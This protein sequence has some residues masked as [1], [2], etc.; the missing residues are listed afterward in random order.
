M[1]LKLVQ[2]F[3]VFIIYSFFGYVMEVIDC[4]LESKKFVNRGFLL[5]PVCPIYG[6]GGLL[7]WF[8]L[9][10]YADDPIVVFV[11]GMLL[12]SIVEYVTGWALEKIFH[13]KWWDYSNRWDSINGHVCLGNSI[14]FGIASL[15]VVYFAHPMVLG[16]LDHFSAF[17]QIL[18]GNI[19]FVLFTADGIYSM[20]VAYNLRNRIIVVEELKNEKAKALPG[21]FEK[22]IRSRVEKWKTFPSRLLKAFPDLRAANFE[23]FEAMRKIKQES[24][25]AKKK[26]KLQKKS[27]KKKK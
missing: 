18:V 2:L 27:K 5:G 1:Y 17:T 16:F 10:S 13:N 23:E 11:F 22:Q 9:K 6:V 4:S 19:L 3:I 15:M 8:C 26:E 21:I 12:T 24:K 25:D 14:L 20:V 7:I